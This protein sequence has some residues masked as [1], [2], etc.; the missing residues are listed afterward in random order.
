M[1]SEDNVCPRCYQSACICQQ[2]PPHSTTS[3]TAAPPPGFQTHEAYQA[4]SHHQQLQQQQQAWYH[5]YYQQQQYQQ[6]HPASLAAQPQTQLQNFSFIQFPSQ[7][8]SDANPSRPLGNSANSAPSRRRTRTDQSASST[9]TT[10][11]RPTRRRRANAGPTPPLTSDAPQPAVAGVGPITDESE[12][13]IPR[14]FSAGTHFESLARKKKS[15]G[16]RTDGASDVWYF[17]RGLVAD[18]ASTSLPE[19]DPPSKE[20]PKSDNFP[21]LECRLCK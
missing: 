11:P 19:Y 8:P 5:H 16:G 1:S 4:W 21:F 15:E 13:T 12:D 2:L 9:T 3:Q 6:Q 14:A 7:D 10:N 20:C 17:T 18:R